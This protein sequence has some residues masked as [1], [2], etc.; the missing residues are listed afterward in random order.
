MTIEDAVASILG[1]RTAEAI[2]KNRSIHW[3]VVAAIGA[4]VP[5]ESDPE[6]IAAIRKWNAERKA[7]LGN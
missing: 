6:A 7:A 1:R 2:I 5:G 3:A 4:T